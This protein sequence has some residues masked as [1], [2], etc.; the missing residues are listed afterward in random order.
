MTMTAMVAQNPDPTRE[1]AAHALSGNLCRC[2][3]YHKILDC[4]LEA[5]RYTRESV[6]AEAN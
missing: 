1:E 5:A 3:D 6:P 4:A 2:C